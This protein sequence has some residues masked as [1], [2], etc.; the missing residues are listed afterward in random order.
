MHQHLQDPQEIDGDDQLWGPSSHSY[1]QV[2]LIV[3]LVRRSLFLLIPIVTRS[4]V[5]RSPAVRLQ[6]TYTCFLL[7]TRGSRFNSRCKRQ[8]ESRRVRHGE[9]KVQQQV[10]KGSSGSLCLQTP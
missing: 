8:S 1:L 6:S 5:T 2:A 9:T 3:D 4:L 10:L 7:S